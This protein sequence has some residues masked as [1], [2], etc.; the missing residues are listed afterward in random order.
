MSRPHDIWFK[1]KIARANL[2]HTLLFCTQGLTEE[3]YRALKKV[4][5]YPQYHKEQ[6][7]VYMEPKMSGILRI[8]RQN[9]LS[10]APFPR[11]YCKLQVIRRILIG[12]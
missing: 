2:D 7:V 6:W 4:L 8:W 1:R 10:I 11:G 5:N 3:R 12:E 9:N